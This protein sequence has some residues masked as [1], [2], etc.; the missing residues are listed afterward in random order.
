MEL[1]KKAQSCVINFIMEMV[2]V[3]SPSPC[4]SVLLVQVGSDEDCQTY[5][6]RATFGG[7]GQWD[8]NVR[9]VKLLRISVMLRLGAWS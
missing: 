8:R 4:I 5:A 9:L 2:L 6:A 3:P 7:G 1:K